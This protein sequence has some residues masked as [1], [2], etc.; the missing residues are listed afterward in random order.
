M[1]ESYRE[2][3]PVC[4]SPEIDAQAEHAECP[5]GHHWT[6]EL[7]ECAD[8]GYIE[9]RSRATLARGSRDCSLCGG[10]LSEQARRKG[11]EGVL[12]EPHLKTR[13]QREVLTEAGTPDPAYESGIF[14]RP[15]NPIFRHKQ[16]RADRTD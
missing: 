13:R 14:T 10:R 16:R 1:W 8:C 11:H 3:C 6:R 9:S 4:D 2:L 15:D 12:L 5:S 7:C